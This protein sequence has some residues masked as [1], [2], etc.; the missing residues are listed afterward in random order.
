MP[1]AGDL[2]LTSAGLG[3]GCVAVATMRLPTPPP[4]LAHPSS[5]YRSFRG[6]L[7]GGSSA[8][9][10]GSQPRLSDAS[11]GTASLRS[12]ELAAH[13]ASDSDNAPSSPKSQI[14]QQLSRA[15][16][17][18][19]R[20]APQPQPSVAVPKNDSEGDVSAAAVPWQSGVSAPLVLGSRSP[21]DRATFTGGGD[22]SG[23]A[24]SSTAATDSGCL[25]PGRS[26]S[27]P[28]AGGR[29]LIGSKLTGAAGAGNARSSMTDSAAMLN[30]SV[31]YLARDAGG[32][33]PASLLRHPS[34]IEQGLNG[35]TP[36]GPWAT[37]DGAS[38]P[39]LP[40][41][42]KLPPSA[43]APSGTAGGTARRR[44]APGTYESDPRLSYVRVLAAEDDPMMRCA[45]WWGE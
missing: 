44:G 15:T 34:D 27:V 19:R 17:S 1:R 39:P 23:G 6:F 12:V 25:P 18:R 36:P 43:A 5:S 33:T 45:W 11:G 38:A 8:G 2:Y 3:K 9:W 41:P 10:G 16:S 29:N 32:E 4:E 37:T 14:A 31:P 42:G 21:Q 24:S 13:T 20:I 7:S 35:S 28:F 40:Q 22:S 26:D 30:N